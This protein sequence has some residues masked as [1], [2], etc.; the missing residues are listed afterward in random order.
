MRKNENKAALLF[1]G[2]A[3]YNCVQAIL[4]H[5]QPVFNTTDQEIESHRSSGSGNIGNGECG[6]YY[7]CVIQAKDNVSV[8]VSLKETFEKEAGSIYCKDI[9]K[10]RKLSCR[11]CVSLA[12][13]VMDQFI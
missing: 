9:R 12:A 6:A 5:Y 13:D 3:R 11:E 2:Q 7:G 4:K 1:R 8:A 10:L